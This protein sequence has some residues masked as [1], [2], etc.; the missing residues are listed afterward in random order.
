LRLSLTAFAGLS[1]VGTALAWWLPEAKSPAVLGR[2]SHGQFVGALALSIVFLTC[3]ALL[4]CPGERRRAIG[5]RLAT[6]LLA[7]GLTLSLWEAGS[8]LLPG[9]VLTHNPWYVWA[10]GSTSASDDLMF[11][12]PP[13]LH[14]E[15]LS[16]GD[17][18]EGRG[19]RYATRVSFDTDFEG[20]RNEQ[21]IREAEIVFIGDSYTEAG[22]VPVH[23]TFAQRVQRALGVS[24][25]NLGRAHHAPAQELIILEKYGLKAKPRVV[26]WQFCETNDLTDEFRFQSWIQEGRPR[27]E[28]F[29]R[30]SRRS[31]W[32]YRSPT[33]RLFELV[34][35]WSAAEWPLSGSFSDAD[36][37]DHPMRFLYL[38]SA[39]QI[40][41]GHHGWP[42]IGRTLRAGAA[43]L[44]GAGIDLIVVAIPMKIR[45]VGPYVIP[46]PMMSEQLEKQKFHQRVDS[47]ARFVPGDAAT[48]L[49]WDIAPRRTFASRLAKISAEL[50]VPFVDAMPA[51]RNLAAQGELVY[52]PY[53]THIS[54]L[55][56]E[57]V[58]QALLSH[59]S[60]LLRAVGRSPR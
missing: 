31:V 43:L 36:G 38:P 3:A 27:T 24:V 57:A 13:N 50:G 52:R 6:V 37:R 28:G 19:T 5:I 59:P 42:S 22:N 51:L 11:E 10:P 41:G 16:T 15:G 54:S 17:I 47:S 4:L 46:S 53:E 26:V 60:N 32:E 23:S 7:V 2:L 12:R 58:A 33:F 45:V 55:G 14:W 8:F 20:F 48:A 21:D 34:R 30:H 1:A 29:T 56:H 40:P 25:R 18:G 35:G 9:D 44:E 39:E 49:P